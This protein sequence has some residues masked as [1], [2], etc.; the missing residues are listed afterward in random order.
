[1]FM[2]IKITVWFYDKTRIVS[3]N[4]IFAVFWFK[5]FGFIYFTLSR[6]SVK[7]IRWFFHI[8]YSR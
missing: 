4:K 1:M 6:W 8:I 2:L 3:L 5:S 7:I